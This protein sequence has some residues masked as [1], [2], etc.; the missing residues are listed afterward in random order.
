MMF[1]IRDIGKCEILCQLAEEAA[2]LAKAALKLRRAIDGCNPTPVTREEAEKKLEEEIADVEV[3]LNVLGYHT[4][5]HLFTQ[6]EIM[7]EKLER[8]SNRLMDAEKRELEETREECSEDG[9]GKDVWYAP[10]GDSK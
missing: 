9:K 8:W 7:Q 1:E 4:D 10:Q 5:E 2:E 6:S 3:C